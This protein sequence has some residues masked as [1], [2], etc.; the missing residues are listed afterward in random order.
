MNKKQA[1]A[2]AAVTLDL[3][4]KIN[5]KV[6]PMILADQMDLIYDLYDLDEIMQKYERLGNNKVCVNSISGK[7]NC[8]IINAFSTVEKQKKRFTEFCENTNLKIGK[9]Y[10][11][12]ARENSEIFYHLIRDIRNKEMEV[13]ILNI[14]TYY[15]MSEEELAVIIR[16]CRKNNINIVEI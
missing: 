5:V 8:Y 15:S 6:T 7:A 14:Y 13:L 9:I 10:V 2:Y 4:Y 12:N 1:K 16:L 11:T 3:L